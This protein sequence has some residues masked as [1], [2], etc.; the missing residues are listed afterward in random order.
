MY[1]YYV[2]I[3][4]LECGVEKINRRLR[5]KQ[6]GVAAEK[7]EGV[8]VVTRCP[9]AVLRAPQCWMNN[10]IVQINLYKY[11]SIEICTH[12]H[13]KKICMCTYTH[14]H[15]SGASV[16]FFRLSRSKPLKFISNAENDGLNNMT[17]DHVGQFNEINFDSRK[18]TALLNYISILGCIFGIHSVCNLQV[19]IFNVIAADISQFWSIFGSLGPVAFSVFL[20]CHPFGGGVIA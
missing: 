4:N 12:I 10:M 1:D 19:H 14:K 13:N 17:L 16:V 6:F 7:I 9:Q 11:I 20:F 2:R 3:W 8:F 5:A 15:T 18:H